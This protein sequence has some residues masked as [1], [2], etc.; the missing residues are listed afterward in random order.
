MVQVGDKLFFDSSL[1]SGFL[2]VTIDRS[3]QTANRI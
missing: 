1:F 2:I 3:T